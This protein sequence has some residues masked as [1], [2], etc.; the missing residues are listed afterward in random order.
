MLLTFNVIYFC[1]LVKYLLNVSIFIW[2]IWFDDKSVFFLILWTERGRSAVTRPV[3]PQFFPQFVPNQARP[4]SHQPSYPLFN[5]VSSSVKIRHVQVVIFWIWKT[6][7]CL[8]GSWLYSLQPIPITHFR[9]LTYKNV[10]L[11]RLAASFPCCEQTT[12]NTTK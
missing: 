5:Q 6:D 12:V 9:E 3:N 4:A 11:T 1:V 2:F 8:S 10:V 7:S